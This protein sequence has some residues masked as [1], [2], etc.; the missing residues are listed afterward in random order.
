MS[1]YRGHIIAAW[2]ELFIVRKLKLIITLSSLLLTIFEYSF[3][4]DIDKMFAYNAVQGTLSTWKIQFEKTALFSVI[5]FFLTMIG[6]QCRLEYDTFSSENPDTGLLA[7]LIFWIF[8]PRQVSSSSYSVP[9]T[10]MVFVIGSL[11]G[12]G[13]LILPFLMF[14]SM[15]TIVI[16]GSLQTQ[17]VL[18]LAFM[19]THKSMKMYLVHKVRNIKHNLFK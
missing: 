3:L 1:V 13:A 12:L 6:L 18:P 7:R 9:A 5:L 11:W 2:D 14:A 8:A 17:V 19:W 16:L 10:R 4:S 15:R